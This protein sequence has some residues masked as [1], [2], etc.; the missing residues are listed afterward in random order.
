MEAQDW[1]Q[2][3]VVRDRNNLGKGGSNEKGKKW[4][5]SNC[6]LEVDLTTG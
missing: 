1:V 4:S 3:F 5:D 2:R 6:M